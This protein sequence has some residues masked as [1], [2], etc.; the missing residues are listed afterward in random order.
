MVKNMRCVISTKRM[1]SHIAGKDRS[2]ALSTKRRALA[3][4]RQEFS[5]IGVNLL[6]C[7]P[8][9]LEASAMPQA[10]WLSSST[11]APESWRLYYGPPRAG[12]L[13]IDRY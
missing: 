9:F 5:H 12:C 11:G 2:P 7:P 13:E 4:R 8:W 10:S 6:E 3:D 1:F